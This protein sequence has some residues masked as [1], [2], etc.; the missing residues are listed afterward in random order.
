MSSAGNQ[1]AG[2]V[3]VYVGLYPKLLYGV[4]VELFLVKDK[5]TDFEY[6]LPSF[7]LAIYSTVSN[8]S[9]DTDTLLCQFDLLKQIFNEQAFSPIS[10]QATI[11]C[12]TLTG[13]PGKKDELTIRWKV[14]KIMYSRYIDR[15]TGSRTHTDTLK[16]RDRDRQTHTFPEQCLNN[17]VIMDEQ[18][19]R[20]DN[21]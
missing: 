16:H 11:K 5:Y 4:V 18:H 3:T 14:R 10:F 9:K 7:A 8:I 6:I 2:F 21:Q 1:K 15:E 13:H 19:C 20:M 17:I 12:P